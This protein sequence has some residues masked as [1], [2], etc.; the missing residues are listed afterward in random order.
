[1]SG[2]Y[3]LALGIL[4]A[5]RV[6]HLLQAEDGPSDIVVRLRLWAAD[7][8]F[9]RLLDCFYCLSIWVSLPL[10]AAIGQ[11]WLER[12]LLWPALS[13]GAILLQQMTDRP[14]PIA[15]VE[16]LSQDTKEDDDGVLR[17]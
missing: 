1:V 10:A 13:G 17:K 16:H 5:W 14:A 8:F 11:G 9:G 2:F 6:T 15:P 4:S 12:I 7:G 3:W